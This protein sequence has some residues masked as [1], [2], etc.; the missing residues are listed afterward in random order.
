MK[1]EP[2]QILVICRHQEI[3]QTILRL[4]RNKPEWEGTGT[5]P[6][7]EAFS[8]IQSKKFDLVLLGAGI[9]PNEDQQLRQS[10]AEHQPE[11]PIVQHYGGGSGLLY[12]EIYQALNNR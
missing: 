10:L 3:L 7:E 9:H 2:I 11:A 1:S 8:Q 12:A 6:G 4:I 5:Q